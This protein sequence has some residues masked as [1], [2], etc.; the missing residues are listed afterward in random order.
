MA[1]KLLLLLSSLCHL[2]KKSTLTGKMTQG[3]EETAKT[4]D[5]RVRRAGFKSQSHNLACG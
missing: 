2:A 4:K 3:W 1:D 5:C